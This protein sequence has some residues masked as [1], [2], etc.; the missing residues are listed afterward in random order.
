MIRA[1]CSP[2]RGVDDT[3]IGS[4]EEVRSRQR[5]HLK[6]AKPRGTGQNSYKIK[7]I[8]Q[9]PFPHKITK[10]SKKSVTDGAGGKIVRY[11][12]KQKVTRK[13]QKMMSEEYKNQQDYT[14]DRL[15]IFRALLCPS[16]GARDYDVDYHIGR[17]FLGLL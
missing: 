11:R 16:S 17:L 5:L 10:N 9:Q 15:N 6:C 14:Y 7:L 12:T 4:L 13:R 8:E 3:V 1:I 2:L